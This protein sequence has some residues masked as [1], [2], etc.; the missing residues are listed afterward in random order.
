M[1]ASIS[2]HRQLLLY[3]RHQVCWRQ[4]FGQVAGMGDLGGTRVTLSCFLCFLIWWLGSCKELKRRRGVPGLSLGLPYSEFQ[5]VL[6]DSST[7]CSS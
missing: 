7:K 5:G 4:L 2:T 6:L 3:F 1:D